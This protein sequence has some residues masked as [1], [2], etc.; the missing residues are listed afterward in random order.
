MSSAKNISYSKT[1][2]R[3]K[4]VEEKDKFHVTSLAPACT[5][6]IHPTQSVL[7]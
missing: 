6:G 2:K 7:C 5:N 3:E 4:V 1:H